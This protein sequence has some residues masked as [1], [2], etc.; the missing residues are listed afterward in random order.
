MTGPYPS[1][2]DETK[3]QPDTGQVGYDGYQQGGYQQP[4]FQQ[5]A[6]AAPVA[7]KSGPDLPVL[8]LIGLLVAVIILGFVWFLTG[9]GGGPESTSAQS[10]SSSTEAPLAPST[11]T[12]TQ[13][14]AKAE[15]VTKTQQSQPRN[16]DPV[17]ENS[18]GK[19]DSRGFFS[20]ARC[21][22]GDSFTLAVETAS[23]LAVICEYSYYRGYTKDNGNVNDTLS[24]VINNNG[25]WLAQKGDT[26]HLV[27]SD[28]ITIW[29]GDQTIDEESAIFSSH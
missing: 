7:Q 6:A 1:N 22:A 8:I 4:P 26:D 18:G 15:T 11:T 28:G 13:E 27:S 10:S 14:P 2:D 23:Y 16:E 29:Q 19:L 3:Y 12:I 25:S 20:G 21:D 9:R 17:A 5:Q 24:A